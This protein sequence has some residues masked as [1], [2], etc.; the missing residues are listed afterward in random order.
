MS[1]ISEVVINHTLPVTIWRGVKIGCL[2]SS[3]V[4]DLKAGEDEEVIGAMVVTREEA[5]W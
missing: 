4:L 5:V 2:A 3:L 1:M